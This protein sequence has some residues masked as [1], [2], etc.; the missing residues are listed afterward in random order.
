MM[1]ETLLSATATL[2]ASG[3]QLVLTDTVTLS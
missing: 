3:D 2:T 1:F